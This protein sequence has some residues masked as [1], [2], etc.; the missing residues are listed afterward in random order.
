MKFTV[1]MKCP[2]ALEYAITNAV[3]CQSASLDMEHGEREDHEPLYDQLKR[4][5]SRWFRY[6]E[7]LTVEVDTEAGTC[8]V[9]P[10]K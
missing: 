3:A 7:Y 8:T 1:S 2:D 10:V 4:V 5:C 6:D 9:C